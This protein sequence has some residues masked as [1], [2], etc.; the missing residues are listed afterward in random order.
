[1]EEGGE[2]GGGFKE[3]LGGGD[4]GA[5]PGLG[6]VMGLLKALS[7]LFASGPKT[8][9]KAP[10]YRAPKTTPLKGIGTIGMA[11][12]G[13]PEQYAGGGLISGLGN[14][15]QFISPFL[16]E[17]L[18]SKYIDKDDED[19]DI[20]ENMNDGGTVLN[21][22]L[23]LGGGEVDGI[24]GPKSDLV[25]I[26]ASDQEYVVSANG[27]KRMGGGNHSRGIA[28]LDEINNNGRLV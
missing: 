23:F 8:V 28:A 20:T 6:D 1:M 2:T 17:L 7:S 25:P 22:K 5:P 21:R 15:L 16:N 9:V 10:R 19:E 13:K 24:G 4:E 27:V 14:L 12:G 18:I 11:Y 26:W 3:W